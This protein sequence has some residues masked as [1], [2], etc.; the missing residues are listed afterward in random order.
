MKTM[1][2]ELFDQGA[3]SWVRSRRCGPANC[4]EVADAGPAVAVRDSKLAGRGPVLMFDR[5]AWS[6]FLDG[7]HA[8]EFDRPAGRHFR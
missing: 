2:S 8:G 5:G 1:D 7:V 6:D 4:V 3:V